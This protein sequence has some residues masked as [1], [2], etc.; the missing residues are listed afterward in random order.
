M[1]GGEINND[2]IEAREKKAERGWLAD[3]PPRLPDFIDRYFNATSEE[4][5]ERRVVMQRRF[6]CLMDKP[7]NWIADPMKNRK[8]TYES[9]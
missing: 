4:F 9:Q 3:P 5:E 8:A 2:R 1:S 7:R 6:K